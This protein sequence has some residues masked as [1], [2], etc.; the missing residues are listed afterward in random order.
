MMKQRKKEVQEQEY[1]FISE[2]IKKR[3]PVAGKLLGKIAAVAVCGVILGVCAVFV[4]SAVWPEEM[5]SMGKDVS[6]L[7]TFLETSDNENTVNYLGIQGITV[8]E[9]QSEDLE[10]PRGIYVDKVETD[11]P[12]MEAGIQNGD[13][14]YLLDG[15][16]V[17]DLTAYTEQLQETETGEDTVL[18]LYRRNADGE[19]ENL[20]LNVIIEK[21]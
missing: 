18:S 13:I 7:Y 17:E 10:I 21:R 2:T 5:E 6:E 14:I 8:S 4:I 15:V 20:E 19:Y 11:S 9:T 12:A 16:K 3:P 1:Y